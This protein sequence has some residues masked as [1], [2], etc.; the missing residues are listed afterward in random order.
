MRRHNLKWLEVR[1]RKLRNELT[2]AEARLWKYLRRSQL[3]GK[4]FRRQHSIGYYILDF[5]CPGA[6]VAI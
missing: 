3:S 4:K 6:R 5:Y 2:P 1:R